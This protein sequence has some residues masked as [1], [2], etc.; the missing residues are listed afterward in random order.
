MALYDSFKYEPSGKEQEQGRNEGKIEQK[1][2]EINIRAVSRGQNE[3]IN[4]FKMITGDV[5][6]IEGFVMNN[7]N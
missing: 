5:I 7:R 2:S 3:L 1:L 4:V 6:S